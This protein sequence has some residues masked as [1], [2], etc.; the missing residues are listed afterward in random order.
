MKYVLYKY[1]FNPLFYAVLQIYRVF[2]AT[3]KQ[4]P[5]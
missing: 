5:K 3:A 2:I 1:M 4:I